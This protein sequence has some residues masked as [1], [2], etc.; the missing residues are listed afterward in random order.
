MQP[1]SVK[2]S[3]IEGELEVKELFGYAQNNAAQFEAYEMEIDIF[4]RVMQIGLAAM[5]CYFTEKGTGGFSL[6][7]FMQ[8]MQGNRQKYVTIQA[9]NKD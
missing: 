4:A 7:L 3:I 8:K 1:Y 9:N 6:I 2:Q 5:K